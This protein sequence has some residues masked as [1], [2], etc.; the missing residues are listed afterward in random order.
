MKKNG[1]T[2]IELLAVIVI[3]A[4]IALIATPII[5]GIINDARKE[6]NE[7]SVELYIS[8]VELAIARRNLEEEFSPEEC[9]ITEGVV[10]CTG[11][12]DPLNVEID[13]ETPVSGTIKFE[14]NKVTTGTT[15]TFSDF[16]ATLNEEGKIVIGESDAGT[17]STPG[18][19]ACS[20][21]DED[22]NGEYSIGDIVSCVFENSTEQFYVIEDED[23]DST[24]TTIDMISM[25]N[26]NV[27]N[28]V[29]P[30]PPWSTTPIENPTGIQDENTG[31]TTLSDGS[32][33]GTVAFD[34][35]DSEPGVYTYVNAYETYLRNN[36]V[37]SAN[38]ALLTETKAEELGVHGSPFVDERGCLSTAPWLCS[39][40]Y[41]LDNG[42]GISLND[43]FYDTNITGETTTGNTNFGVRPVITISTSD[44]Q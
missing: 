23:N 38:A 39:R 2:L 8:G 6:S 43:G 37:S 11:Y 26:L 22:S 1:F 41:W 25:Y 10:T 20:L 29:S 5:L 15:L 44:I 35:T 7:R 33:Y 21:S 19:K 4:I 42:N 14:N 3:L 32:W 9:T 16:T 31:V 12:E 24:P 34:K 27:G 30:N 13:G 28:V 17:S 36:G 40:A 18:A